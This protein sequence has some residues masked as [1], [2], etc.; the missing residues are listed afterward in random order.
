MATLNPPTGVAGTFTYTL[1]KVEDKNSSVCTTPSTQ[2]YVVIV[3]PVPDV[4]NPGDQSVC[5]LATESVTF[6][7]S[8]SG[9]VYNWTNDNASIGLAGTGS[10]DLSFKATNTTSAAIVA[11]IMVTP[12]YTSADKTCTGTPVSFTIT[13]D[14][15]PNADQVSNVTYCK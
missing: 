3:N 7:G 1:T 9:T 13:V 2:T 4:T 10:G 5:N 6:T 8:V 15:T 12:T 11:H 14:P